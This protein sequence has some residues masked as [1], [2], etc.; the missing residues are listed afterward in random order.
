MSSKSNS[1]LQFESDDIEYNHII[2]RSKRRSNPSLVIYFLVFITVLSLF[3]TFLKSYQAHSLSNQL[4]SLKE[5]NKDLKSYINVIDTQYNMFTDTSA[6]VQKMILNQIFY[7]HSTDVL[8]TIDELNLIR[9]W[10]GKSTMR[11]IFKSSITGDSAHSF[12]KKVKKGSDLLFLVKTKS[13]HRFGGYTSK[14]FEPLCMNGFTL[15]TEKDD[16]NSF[17]FSLNKQKR[18]KIKDKPNALYCDENI[19]IA[20]GEGDIFIGDNFF[21]QKSRSFFPQSYEG[22]KEKESLLLTGGESEF[23]IEELEVYQLYFVK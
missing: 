8:E 13:G 16:S 4:N 21:T 6:S 20:L 18:F 23:I 15:D 7:P 9:S 1:L 2:K 3:I 5:E 19:S 14:N 11:L 12:H 22:D 10:V 17:L